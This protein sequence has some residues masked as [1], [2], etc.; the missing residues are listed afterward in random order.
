[1]VKAI[2][3]PPAP[4][5]RYIQRM[6]WKGVNVINGVA[7]TGK[8]PKAVGSGIFGLEGQD[9][10]VFDGPMVP[11]SGTG[12]FYNDYAKDTTETQQHDLEWQLL[13]RPGRPLYPGSSARGIVL[14]GPSMGN[15][16]GS[17]NGNGE[18]QSSPLGKLIAGAAII[19]GAY[20]IL[21][22]MLK[23]AK[24]GE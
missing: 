5:R 8:F 13:R 2:V 22:T 16:N 14:I 21:S 12:I 11:N 24:E 4:D 1:M 7:P 18:Q 17:G 23:L 10:G 15:D 20:F 19:G 6:G 3:N 9:S